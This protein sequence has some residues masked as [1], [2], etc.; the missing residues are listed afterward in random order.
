M[1]QTYDILR[2]KVR[3]RDKEAEI[4]YPITPR[5]VVSYDSDNSTLASAVLVVKDIVKIFEEKK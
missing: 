2:I 4:S 5:T 3:I 1:A